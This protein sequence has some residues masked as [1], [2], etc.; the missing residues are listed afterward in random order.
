[1]LSIIHSHLDDLAGYEET[2]GPATALIAYGREFPVMLEAPEWLRL[3]ADKECFKN[4]AHLMLHREDVDYAEG[5]AIDLRLPIPIQ[6]AW[7][8]DRTGRVID[9][10]WPDSSACVFRHRI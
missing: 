10:T 6:H 7:L 5:F 2:F 8:L 4:A 9:P 3:A 1:M